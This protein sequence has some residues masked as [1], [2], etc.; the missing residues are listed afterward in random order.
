MLNADKIQ[1]T[2]DENVVGSVAL[3]FEDNTST[4][5]QGRII[6]KKAELTPIAG[7]ELDFATTYVI[8]LKVRDSAWESG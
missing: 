1:I 5:W 8:V 6:G 2:F 7:R 3:N 4:D